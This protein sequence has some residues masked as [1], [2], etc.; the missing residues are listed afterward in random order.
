LHR[1]VP[2]LCELVRRVFA[3]GLQV[4]GKYLTEIERAIAPG[5]AIAGSVIFG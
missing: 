1:Q 2:W 5:S 4:S 3:D